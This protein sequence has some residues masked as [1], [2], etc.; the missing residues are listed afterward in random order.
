VVNINVFYCPK[1]DT[2]NN[3]KF[4]SLVVLRSAETSC[5]GWICKATREEEEEEEE[6]E[7]KEEEIKN[8]KR[9]RRRKRKIRNR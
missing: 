7:E 1:V 4:V 2:L 5:C 9:K 6:E 8:K 3:S